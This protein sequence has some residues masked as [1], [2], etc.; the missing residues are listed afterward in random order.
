M[1][2]KTSLNK[3][4]TDR[5][6]EESI[7]IYSDSLPFPYDRLVKVPLWKK[8]W[9]EKRLEKI[10]NSLINDLEPYMP[11]LKESYQSEVNAK[12][13]EAVT[14]V[15]ELIYNA[16]KLIDEKQ[17]LFDRP[18]LTYFMSQGYMDVAEAFIQRVNSEDPELKNEEVFQA[19]R[20]IWIMNSLQLLWDQ[21]ITLTSPMYAYSLL[22]PYTDNLLDNSEIRLSDKEAFN[23]GLRQSLKQ[24]PI[25]STNK[26]EARIY[27][28]VKMIHT[29]FP[30]EDYPDVCESIILIHKA[31]IESMKQHTP[32][33]LSRNDLLRIS[34]FKGG[35][36]VLADAYLIK[37]KLTYEEMF[38]SFQYGAFLQLLDDL[39]DKAE[40][41][42]ESSQT[43]FTNLK[44][45]EKADSEIRRVIAYIHSVNTISASDNSNSSLLKEVISQCTL[46]MIMEAVG[47][48]PSIISDTFYKELESYS[49]VRLSF[50]KHLNEKIKEQL[51][52]LD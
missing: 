19:L 45:G 25:H 35:T 13:S 47:K 29:D 32:L 6:L 34:F 7:S 22:Y 27:D 48:Q 23:D 52:V 20:N 14:K 49:K 10:I 24:L 26:T 18:F 2:E 31:Q 8:M 36:S 28:L 38:F 43:L 51:D 30:I 46:L 40:D 12:E 33:S 17:L 9:N 3:M 39:Q 16:L 50:Y 5:L 15:K 21:K 41:E 42:R 37:G 11:L 44:T 4:T 1:N